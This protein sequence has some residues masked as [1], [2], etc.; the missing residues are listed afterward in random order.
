VHIDTMHLAHPE[1]LWFFAAV[2]LLT[3]RAAIGRARRVRDWSALGQGG[4]PA[5]DGSW[6]WLAAVSCL[7]VAMTQPRW[8][9]SERPPSPPGRDVVLAIDVSRSM[10]ARDAV[11]DRLGVAVDAAASLVKALGQAGGERAAIVAFAGRGVLRCPLTENLGAVSEALRA[12][13]PGGVR[14]GGTNLAAALDSAL[15]AFDDQEHS[16]GRSVVLFTDGEDHASPWP[17]VVARLRA[18]GVMV[19]TVAVGDPE[20]GHTVPAKPGADGE[21]IR[22]QGSV[23]LSRRSDEPLQTI[24]R[25]TGGAF[26]PIGLATA[27]LGKLYRTR[28]E[29]EARVR[30]QAVLS[31]DPTERFPL[32]LFAS[33]AFGIFASWPARPRPVPGRGWV[34]LLVGLAAVIGAGPRDEAPLPIPAGPSAYAAGRH[35]EA[36]AAFRRAMTLAPG[37]AIPAY[38]AASALYQIGRYVESQALYN[39]ART[40]ADAGL[41]IKID[42]ALGNTALALGDFASAI[43]HYDDCLVSTVAGAELDVVRE[44]AAINREFAEEQARRSP[45]PPDDG[46]GSNKPSRPQKEG[47]NKPEPKGQGGGAGGPGEGPEGGSS[48]G[49]RGP[50]GAG[51]SGP[52]PPR[53]GSPEDQL[54][55]ALENVRESRLLRIDE[56]PVA[57]DNENV[58]DW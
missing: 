32:F 6:H 40:R 36:V 58:K 2:P 10:A 27:D 16:G 48:S 42:Y 23:V 41:R 30:R 45:S 44:Y 19:H 3:M 5:R 43:R 56:A 34:T 21:P 13:K 47:E 46:D 31:P 26:I 37:S 20:H 25:E 22:Y 28:I 7:A 8:G 12:L 15:D 51:G 50:G 57:D 35:D 39:E 53:T 49:R 52:A 54:S 11:P 33:L 29:P 24:A 38:D 4:R 14:P 1:W 18:Q 55:K 17:I 9:R